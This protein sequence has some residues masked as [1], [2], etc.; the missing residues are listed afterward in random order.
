MRLRLRPRPR[1][2]VRFS[3]R[4]RFRVKVRVSKKVDGTR[5][6]GWLLLSPLSLSDLLR[7]G[8]GVRVRVKVRV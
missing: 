6:Y 1:V 8:L 3:A 2:R 4:I 5:A 7:S